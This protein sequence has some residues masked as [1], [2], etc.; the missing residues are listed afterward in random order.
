MRT[1]TSTCGSDGKWLRRRLYFLR[2]PSDHENVMSDRCRTAELHSGDLRSSGRYI[3]LV[4]IALLAIS[5]SLRASNALAAPATSAEP[6]PE[7]QP[8][9]NLPA[10]EA[11]R[12]VFDQ[13]RGCHSL[14]PSQNG[15]G[16]TLYHLFG[17]R[18]GS[19]PGYVYSPAM[20]NSVI[21]WT[22]GTLDRY[23]RNPRGF[24]PGS[25]MTSP[26]IKDPRDRKNLLAFLREATK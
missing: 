18:A 19:V 7:S 17:R 2:S 1:Q 6:E 12:K 5:P 9:Q 14:S 4:L 25:K 20:K 3:F 26:D 15:R 24:V 22:A 8:A 16:P 11:G 13:C 23:L 10:P 21:V